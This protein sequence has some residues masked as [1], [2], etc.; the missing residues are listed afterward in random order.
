M[1][2]KGETILQ[3]DFYT[4]AS[5]Q[6]KSLLVNQNAAVSENLTVIKDT[7]VSV[8]L[9][10]SKKTTTQTLAVSADAVISGSLSA[11]SGPANGLQ[12]NG[13][14]M[15]M[16][17]AMV[18]DNLTVYKNLQVMGN[19][20]GNVNVTNIDATDITNVTINSA[21][22]PP[23]YD[24]QYYAAD[25]YVALSPNGVSDTTPTWTR[26]A[27]ITKN[28]N[29]YVPIK[30]NIIGGMGS[31]STLGWGAS[32]DEDY[33]IRY[34]NATLTTFNT[35]YR[36]SRVTTY[37]AKLGFIRVS[38]KI[39]DV[40]FYRETGQ[41]YRGSMLFN[42]FS[43]DLITTYQNE[44]ALTDDPGVTF[45]PQKLGNIPTPPATGNYTLQS[46]DRLLSWIAS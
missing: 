34:S 21:R 27:T 41:W 28:T 5:A 15:A 46:N 9:N 40:Y 23:P 17:D 18:S 42:K 44:T 7:N 36:M 6:M 26:I 12:V 33:Y 43:T 3:G 37:N 2:V 10:V 30:F 20:S 16:S 1:L 4:N 22:L 32:F 31:G 38:A 8:N 24:L 45:L 29:E 13:V 35:S 25:Y 19:I 39:T 14:L 11:G